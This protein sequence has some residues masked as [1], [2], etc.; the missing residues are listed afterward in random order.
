MFI[1]PADFPNATFLI[2]PLTI[3]LSYTSFYIVSIFCYFYGCGTLSLTP[4]DRQ[5]R[6][7]PLYLEKHLVR[8]KKKQNHQS[9]EKQK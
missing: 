6:P 9:S 1:N 4:I 7:F 3:C 8:P 5:G 2:E